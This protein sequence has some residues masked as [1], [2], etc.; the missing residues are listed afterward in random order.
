[1][2]SNLLEC[3]PGIFLTK[4]TEACLPNDAMLKAIND[5]S[6]PALKKA[7]SVRLLFSYLAR[8]KLNGWFPAFFVGAT[9]EFHRFFIPN[10]TVFGID[11]EGFINAERNVR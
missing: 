11:F 1:M 10:M 6:F 9:P 3:G 5:A 8:K 7:A 2:E 4:V